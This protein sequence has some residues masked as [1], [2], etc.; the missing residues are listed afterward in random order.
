MT[1]VK[2]TYCDKTIRDVTGIPEALRY[3]VCNRCRLL[4]S[5]RIESQQ[6]IMDIV[7]M[8][9]RARGYGFFKTV[10]LLNGVL[11]MAKEE[12]KDS[13]KSNNL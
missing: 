10:Q 11:K 9:A 8:K 1:L 4:G 13:L 2:C 12:L 5:Y 6:F 7:T 3:E